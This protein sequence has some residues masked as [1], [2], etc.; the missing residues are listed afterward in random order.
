MGYTRKAMGMRAL[1]GNF[2]LPKCLE[3]ALYQGINK[4]DGKQWG[5]PTP[6]PLTFT[7]I[8]D[9]IQA[10]LSQARFFLEKLTTIYSIVDV[11]DGEWLRQPFLSALMDGCIERGQDC[12][13]YKYFPNTIIMPVGQITV[14]NSLAAIKKL[15]FDEKKVT[16][17][18]L[19][20]A[21][22]KNWEGRR[23][24]ARCFSMHLS[25]GTMT[26]MWIY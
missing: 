14:V 20:E 24:C 19:V 15:V 11:L 26:T 5:Y 13:Q 4:I 3:Y 9:V 6:D 7:S 10:Y 22:R 12:R 18:E 8:E 2:A 16:M 1:G 25:L 21:L 17:S 23:S